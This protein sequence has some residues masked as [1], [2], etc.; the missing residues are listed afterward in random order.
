MTISRMLTELMGGELTVRSTPGAG[1]VFGV[2]LFLPELAA[3][4]GLVPAG[5]RHGYDGPRRRI[6]V[7]DNE[8]ADR[9]LLADLLQ[10]LGFLIE[11]AGSGE[12]VLA[13]LADAAAPLPDAIFMD[14]AMPGIDGWETILRLRA[15]GFGGI[16]L[17]VVSANAFDRGLDHEVALP[18][19]DFLVKPV[20]LSK[21]LDWLGE[22]LA[23]RWS[24]APVAPPA[25]PE[26]LPDAT[27]L[28]ALHALVEQGFVRGIQKKLDEI[29]A[30]DS[31]AA[32][33]VARLRT[34]A[35]RFE[36]DA[37]G[38]AVERALHA[39]R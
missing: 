22:R 18:E 13:R 7:V 26:K 12:A 27:Q 3:A 33:F 16:P 38:A 30:A 35:Q 32:G 2:R 14:L 28:E 20:R 23:L 17:A 37:L 4:P 34:L 39:T 24:A 1:S 36:I 11:G 31:G 19:A 15:S 5:P 9:T 6:L 10:P 8:E 29:E 21:L 25:A